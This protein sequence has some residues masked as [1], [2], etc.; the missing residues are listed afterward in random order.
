MAPSG[1]KAQRHKS[2]GKL[3]QPRN[4]IQT[5]GA[6]EIEHSELLLPARTHWETQQNFRNDAVILEKSGSCDLTGFRNHCKIGA[7][8]PQEREG[9]GRCG[10]GNER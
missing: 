5:T 8:F 1:S 10:K 2:Q 9:P 3:G 4:S 6:R 7:A